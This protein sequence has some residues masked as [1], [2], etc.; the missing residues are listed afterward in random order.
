[1]FFPILKIGFLSG[2][3]FVASLYLAGFGLGGIG[4]GSLWQL[5]PALANF[6]GSGY[7]SPAWNSADAMASVSALSSTLMQRLAGFSYSL[8]LALGTDQTPGIAA[9]SLIGF[10]LGKTGRHA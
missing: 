2:L 8:N 3:A 5:F 10:C 7:A 9:A 6:G 4:Q 1:M